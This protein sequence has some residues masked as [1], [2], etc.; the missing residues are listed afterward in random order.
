MC[1]SPSRSQ[2]SNR[3][4]RMR[5]LPPC[6]LR[7]SRTV[8]PIAAGIAIVSRASFGW[9][10]LGEMIGLARPRAWHLVSDSR[11]RSVSTRRP[12]S[13]ESLRVSVPGWATVCI[14][15]QDGGR[16]EHTHPS[17]AT[18]PQVAH[19]S[20]F[21]PRGGSLLRPPDVWPSGAGTRSKPGATRTVSGRPTRQAYAGWR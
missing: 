1:A 7:F 12:I 4:T 11:P 18:G 17:A 19:S 21:P 8:Y 6:A 9:S 16:E 13:G 3:R 2:A 5:T 14:P 20:A 10:P 15:C